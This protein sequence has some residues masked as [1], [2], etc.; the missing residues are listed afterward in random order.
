MILRKVSNLKPGFSVEIGR[1]DLADEFQG[2]HHN[3]AEFTPA[4]SLLENI[5]GSAYEFSYSTN[6]RNGNTIFHRLVKPL[7]AGRSYVSPDRR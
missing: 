2:Y 4:D 3:G 7:E 6:P 5:I 1:L